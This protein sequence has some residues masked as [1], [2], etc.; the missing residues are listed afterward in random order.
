[1]KTHYGQIHSGIE[2]PFIVT[3]EGKISCIELIFYLM[4]KKLQFRALKT[5]VF[6]RLS[7]SNVEF[8]VIRRRFFFIFE[9]SVQS[10]KSN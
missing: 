5:S 3:D 6:R 9:N 4:D 8:D 7:T 10:L 1:M 2:G